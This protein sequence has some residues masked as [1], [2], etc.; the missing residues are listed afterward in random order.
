[1]PR[2]TFRCLRCSKVWDGQDV[3]RDTDA[4]SVRWLCGDPACVSSVVEISR[5]SKASLM[6]YGMVTDFSAVIVALV[7]LW[8]PTASPA[9]PALYRAAAGVAGIGTLVSAAVLLCDYWRGRF[10]PASRARVILLPLG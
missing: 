10:V 3:R 1:M 9:V 5:Q 7:L 4:T 6:H 8:L 2:G